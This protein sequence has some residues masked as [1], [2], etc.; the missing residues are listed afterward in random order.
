MLQQIEESRERLAVLTHRERGS[1]SSSALVQ[2]PKPA[3]N[4]KRPHIHR[5]I[6]RAELT[7]SVDRAYKAVV[8]ERHLNGT[9]NGAMILGIQVWRGDQRQWFALHREG[10]LAREDCEDSQVDIE[11]F[12]PLI[13]LHMSGTSGNQ[14]AAKAV[15]A[16]P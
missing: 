9:F 5:S 14:A 16:L 7:Y 10:A 8:Y 13:S 12:L 6:K 4:R 3:N 2:V 1:L 15:L 11:K